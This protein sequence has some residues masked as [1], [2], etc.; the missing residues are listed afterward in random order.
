MCNELNTDSD[1][2]GIPDDEDNYSD[3]PMGQVQVIARCYIL[4]DGTETC[5]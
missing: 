1:G 2:D 3:D 4:P 5:I